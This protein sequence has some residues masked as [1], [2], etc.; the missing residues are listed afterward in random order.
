MRHGGPFSIVLPYLNNVRG[1]GHVS[2]MM[3]TCYRWVHRDGSWKN[4]GTPPKRATEGKY[5][6]LRIPF[7]F[8]FQFVL[9]IGLLDHYS[10]WCAPHP[11]SN[12]RIE[13]RQ[14]LRPYVAPHWIHSPEHTTTIRATVLSH[15][16]QLLRP[17]LLKSYSVFLPRRTVFSPL[18]KKL[19][20]LLP[21]SRCWHYYT[22]CCSCQ[23]NGQ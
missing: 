15:R 12:N 6:H 21:L 14:F 18:C 5:L 2:K 10:L 22:C 4:L 20:W 16:R 3:F 7:T 8:C 19:P 17:Y 9:F 1:N 13:M 11:H 23:C